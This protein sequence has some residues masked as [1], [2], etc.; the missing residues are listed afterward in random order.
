MEESQFSEEAGGWRPPTRRSVE[1]D[2]GKNLSRGIADLRDSVELFTG[3][4]DSH[5]ARTI[6]D[7]LETFQMLYL[8]A[9]S[10]LPALHH[11]SA[12]FQALKEEFEEKIG[13]EERALKEVKK[14]M[15]ELEEEIIN[16]YSNRTSTKH[17]NIKAR[18]VQIT[19]DLQKLKLSTTNTPLQN[20]LA[21]LWEEFENRS[22]SVVEILRKQQ[23][24]EV[25][26][27]KMRLKMEEGYG[28]D[29][30]EFVKRIL[31][32]RKIG[33]KDAVTIVRKKI[34][35]AEVKAFEKTKK[36]WKDFKVTRKT[37]EAV[38]KFVVKSY[39]R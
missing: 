34:L 6:R 24:E 18:I 27:V 9:P 3:G 13:A 25:S 5:Q 11:I 30:I 21:V 14:Q 33:G 2:L 26:P 22:E 39:C 12:E 4:R 10:G 19:K 32:E 31:K 38:Q 20:R 1:E 28:Q 15:E 8:Q 29:L 35:P 17:D 36:D 23:D 7:H 37:K 16:Y